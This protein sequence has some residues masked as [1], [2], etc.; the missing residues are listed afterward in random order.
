M[1][2][3]NKKMIE[4]CAIFLIVIT[5]IVIG[6][7][8]YQS[9]SKQK[10]EKSDVVK[11][12]NYY[13]PDYLFNNDYIKIP[14]TI[15]DFANKEKEVYM[16]LDAE[17][18]LYI[19]FTNEKTSYNKHIT[20]LPKEKVTVYYN[21]LY[22][23]YYEFV[24]LTESKNLYYTSLDLNSKK[25]ASFSQIGKQINSVYVPSYDKNMVYV[26]KKG[27]LI[28]NF[29]FSDSNNNLNY[30]DYEK[31]EYI[32]KEGIEKVKPY[33]NY[34]CASDN[35]SLCNDIMLYQ[36]FED[37]LIFSYND[38]IIKNELQEEIIVKDMFATLKINSEKEVD[39]DKI[40]FNNLNKKYDYLFT[41]YI[42]DEKDNYYKLEINKK[43][44]KEKQENRALI[45]SEKKVKQLIFDDERDK[46][47]KVHIVYMD[48]KEEQ[49]TENTN[50]K[51]ITSTT[52]DKNKNKLIEL[53]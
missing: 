18:N 8:T 34:I 23:N 10:E 28:T 51:I 19:K 50:M 53:S 3:K 40:S 38:K 43:V 45:S 5:F 6:Y 4:W 24:A 42:I 11:V 15:K 49:I 32:L 41:V 35:S 25:D 39:L 21:N 13:N 48:G 47:K 31:G 22:D 17:N 46:P 44:L 29:I 52:Y 2:P 12:D 27:N 26:N 37:K 16:Y 33:F 36:T 14:N 1:K 20:N 9:Y 7:Y 30:L